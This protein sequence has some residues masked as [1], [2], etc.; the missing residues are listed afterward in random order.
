MN[1]RTCLSVC[2]PKSVRQHVPGKMKEMMVDP[3]DP[4][5]ARTIE[6][7]RHVSDAS[8]A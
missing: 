4:T 7:E 8:S 6:R 1:M 2:S 5:K 3:V